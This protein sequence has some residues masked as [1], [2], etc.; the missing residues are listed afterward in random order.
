MKK[1]FAI[2]ILPREVILDTQGRAVQG[3]LVRDG[4]PVS[5]VRVGQW[6]EVELDSGD[7]EVV[8]KIAKSLVN[9][10]IQRFEVVKL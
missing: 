1:K 9:P 7:E 6:I 10:L 8:Q 5:Q 4:F 2:Q 3:L